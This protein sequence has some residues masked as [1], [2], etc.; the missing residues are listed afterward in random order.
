MSAAACFPDFDLVS[1]I[2]IL[3]LFELKIYRRITQGTSF[4]HSNRTTG[5]SKI[6]NIYFSNHFIQFNL[7]RIHNLV[8][9]TM[10]Y[11]SSLTPILPVSTSRPTIDHFHVTAAILVY[12]NNEK[13]A[14][15]VYQT[16]PVG[17][18]LLSYVK[19]FFYPIHLHGC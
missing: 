15:L 17:V 12:Q 13:A 9:I 19:T 11:N 2:D 18:K 8:L 14:M 3:P 7:N 1:S 5:S 10:Q 6:H 16:N 4:I